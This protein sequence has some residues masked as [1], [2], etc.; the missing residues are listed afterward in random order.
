MALAVALPPGLVTVFVWCIESN[1]VSKLFWFSDARVNITRSV[2]RVRIQHSHRLICVSICSRVCQVSLCN[3]D[4]QTQR[5]CSMWCA[6][7]LSCVCVS[8]WHSVLISALLCPRS[9]QISAVL[10]ARSLS[11]GVGSRT[12]CWAASR[13]LP[14]HTTVSVISQEWPRRLCVFFKRPE[15]LMVDLCVSVYSGCA[16]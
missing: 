8:R 10:S 5:S 15:T 9:V 14:Y 1:K 3:V 7:R 12:T 16:Q 4:V 2:S 13:L 11:L 6:R